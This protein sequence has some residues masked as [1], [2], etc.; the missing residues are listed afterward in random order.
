MMRWWMRHYRILRSKDYEN[1]NE[2]NWKRVWMATKNSSKG[3]C[4]CFEI[5]V[6]YIKMVPVVI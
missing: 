2:Q 5:A 4:G 1:S 3:K 6:K